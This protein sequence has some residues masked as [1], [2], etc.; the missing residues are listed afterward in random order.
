MI[1]KAMVTVLIAFSAVL[2]TTDYLL[3]Q[4]DMDPNFLALEMT[5]L[6]S[7]LP[8]CDYR[9][10]SV[11]K[12]SVAWHIDHSL[13]VIN[14]ITDSLRSS[15]AKDYRYTPNPL[16][17]LVFATGKMR[18]GKGRAPEVVLPPDTIKMNDLLTQWEDAK[19]NLRFLDSVDQQS[20]FRHPVFG[21][22]NL[23]ASKRFIAI[24]TGHHLEIIKDIIKVRERITNYKN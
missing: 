20:H 12:V 5:D 1:K 21:V 18:R 14:R 10:G 2:L 15:N 24:H 17:T 16:R 6:E 8:Y 3:M 11:S 23:K 22:L 19:Q 4:K 9:E 13:K 7:K